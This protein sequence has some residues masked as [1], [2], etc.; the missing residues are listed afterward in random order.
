MDELLKNLTCSGEECLSLILIFVN[1]LAVFYLV[2]CSFWKVGGFLKFIGW[3]WLGVLFAVT[4][5]VLK[6]HICIYTLIVTVFTVMMLVAIL[7]VILPHRTKEPVFEVERKVAPSSGNNAV[8]TEKRETSSNSS[9][10]TYYNR[11]G[12]PYSAPRQR[13]NEQEPYANPFDR[14]D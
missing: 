10:T 3:I 7:S 12:S 6:S 4:I 9:M 13:Q 1:I 8:F 5:K 2:C 11:P 14:Y